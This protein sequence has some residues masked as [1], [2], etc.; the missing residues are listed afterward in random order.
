MD[1]VVE[2][3]KREASTGCQWLW[4]LRERMDLVGLG[5]PGLAEA[6]HL[7]PGESDTATAADIGIPGASARLVDPETIRLDQGSPRQIRS[8]SQ[9][10]AGVVGHRALCAQ[11]LALYVRAALADLYVNRMDTSTRISELA[12]SWHGR[13]FSPA[14][15]TPDGCLEILCSLH[16]AGHQIFCGD[17]RLRWAHFIWQQ[18]QA[19]K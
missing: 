3:L 14:R 17:E 1:V 18:K 4:W 7:A 9:L 8:W 10:A 2:T 19:T 16:H 13:G 15:E 6:I 5:G 11:A 12:W